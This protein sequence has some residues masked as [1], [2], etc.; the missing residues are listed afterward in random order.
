[1]AQMMPVVT[2]V[3]EI[4]KEGRR[5][6]RRRHGCRREGSKSSSKAGAA[7][8]AEAVHSSSEVEGAVEGAVKGVVEGGEEEGVV[9]SSNVSCSTAS[10]GRAK[11]SGHNSRVPS[12]TSSSHHQEVVG[13]R[14][15][16]A[17]R[18]GRRRGVG[19][20]G[21]RRRAMMNE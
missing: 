11:T 21:I 17:V 2:V 4:V 1:M 3:M 8:K 5:R 12:S 13:I 10:S 9:G 15:V 7:S 16:M 19:G 18:K 20:V 6:V 14:A